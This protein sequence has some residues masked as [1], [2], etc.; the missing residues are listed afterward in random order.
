[1]RGFRQELQRNKINAQ[2][3]E[4]RIQ[5]AKLKWGFIQQNL[6]SKKKTEELLAIQKWS[7]DIAKVILFFPENDLAASFNIP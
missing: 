3:F 5:K 4:T 2:A 6:D 1:M 7:E